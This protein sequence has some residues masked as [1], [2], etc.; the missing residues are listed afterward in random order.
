MDFGISKKSVLKRPAH[1]GCGPDRLFA[2]GGPCT[3][4]VSGLIVCAEPSTER[5]YSG[6]ANLAEPEPIK[7][8][9]GARDLSSIRVLI[10][11]S[12]VIVVKP[13]NSMALRS[14]FFP[15]V[16]SAPGSTQER[17]K[18]WV[19]SLNRCVSCLDGQLLSAQGNA[20]DDGR[21]ILLV[22]CL[23]T[24]TFVRPIPAIRCKLGWYRAKS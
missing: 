20:A 2:R 19:W 5:I 12:A 15:A 9:H 13:L 21:R 17:A 10:G 4:P 16:R 6:D 3:C 14:L 8:N 18:D 23:L 22:F 11:Y 1:P 7:V 24:R